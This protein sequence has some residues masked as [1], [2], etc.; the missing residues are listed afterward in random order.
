MLCKIPKE[1]RS[2]VLILLTVI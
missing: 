2:C 1:H